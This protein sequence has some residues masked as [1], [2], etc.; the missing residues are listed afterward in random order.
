MCKVFFQ[1]LFIYPSKHQQMHDLAFARPSGSGDCGVLCMESLQQRTLS[2]FWA[3][4][5]GVQLIKTG[6]VIQASPGIQ[7]QPLCFASPDL[8]YPFS[9]H[10]V[11]ALLLL[12]TSVGPIA[13]LNDVHRF[14]QLFPCSLLPLLW[15]FIRFMVC[16][17]PFISENKITV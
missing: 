4:G 3:A 11:F 8:K 1:S 15:L 12:K 6:D 16:G 7:E 10:L 14:Y 9:Y 2:L 5:N 13:S 17:M